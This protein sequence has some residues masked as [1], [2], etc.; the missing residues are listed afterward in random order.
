MGETIKLHLTFTF[1]SYFDVPYLKL[2]YLQGLMR[3]P[4]QRRHLGLSDQE[5]GL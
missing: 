5:A 3:V 1:L 2:W 4:L